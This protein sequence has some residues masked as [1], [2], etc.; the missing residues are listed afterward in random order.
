M[1]VAPSS[2]TNGESPRAF[3]L[4]SWIAFS[5]LIVHAISLFPAVPYKIFYLYAGGTLYII[6]IFSLMRRSFPFGEILEERRVL[7]FFALMP[8]SYLWTLYPEET[9]FRLMITSIYLW[10]YLVARLAMRL[11]GRAWFERLVV[12]IPYVYLGMFAY[13]LFNYGTVRPVDRSMSEE[14]GSVCN[15]GPGIVELCLP[16]LLFRAV[17]LRH[18]RL[19]EWGAIGAAIFITILSQSRGAYI[20]FALTLGLLGLVLQRTPGA[21]AHVRFYWI[22]VLLTCLVSVIVIVVGYDKT[23]GIVLERIG[24]SQLISISLS[25]EPWQGESDFSRALSYRAALELLRTHPFK[26]I[27]YGGFGPF[28]EDHFGRFSISHNLIV[29]V[30]GELGLPGLLIFGSILYMTLSRLLRIW[31]SHRI[32]EPEDFVFW[33]ACLVSLVVALA[34]GMFRP[35]MDNPMFFVLL[36]VAMSAPNVP[37]RRRMALLLPWRRGTARRKRSPRVRSRPL[38]TDG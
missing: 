9:L 29:S 37:A 34:H 10:L 24:Q 7:A 18:T 22:L 17:C 35:V 23:I 15:L 30:W 3:A 21:R 27:G 4:Y 6:L 26:G 36:A 11:E 33:C 16:F 8:L 19:F 5:A 25:E 14:I 13:L 32:V 38:T 31:A 2:A 28:F 12:A 1:A 20:M